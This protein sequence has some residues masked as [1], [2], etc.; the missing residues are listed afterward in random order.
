MTREP[1]QNGGQRELRIES[2]PDRQA[3]EVQDIN[4]IP[5]NPFVQ[6]F[7]RRQS[8]AAT[9]FALIKK[10]WKSPLRLTPLFATPEP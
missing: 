2:E 9:S 8:L 7:T 4:H 10:N 6:L 3:T 1:C 5:C